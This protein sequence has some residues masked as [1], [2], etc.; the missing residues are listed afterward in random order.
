M[1]MG[2]KDNHTRRYRVCY[3]TEDH[4]DENRISFKREESA[5]LYFNT[6]VKKDDDGDI[7]TP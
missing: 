4:D 7:R 2:G 3:R 5:K 1:I 6:V